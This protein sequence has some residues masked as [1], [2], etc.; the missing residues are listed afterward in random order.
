MTL[1]SDGV[2]DRTPLL[3][4]CH[5]ISHMGLDSSTRSGT[6]RLAD[7][8][9]ELLEVARRSKSGLLM[10][11]IDRFYRPDY[12]VQANRPSE[13][14][15]NLVIQ[16]CFRPEDSTDTARL[17]YAQRFGP[18]IADQFV[19]FSTEAYEGARN[20][21]A[22]CSQRGHNDCSPPKHHVDG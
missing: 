2:G 1:K 5:D 17:E 15:Q 7:Y 13:H 14:R 22:Q 9:S 3:L 18:D 11:R 4:S 21:I 8:D 10:V 16:R 12:L 20:H 19:A 6:V